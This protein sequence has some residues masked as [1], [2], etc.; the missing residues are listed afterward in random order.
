MDV[1]TPVQDKMLIL[2]RKPMNFADKNAVAVFKEN[3]IVG[4]VP[5]N[6]APSLSHFLKRDVNMVFGKVAGE[7]LTEKRGMDLEFREST[8]FMGQ[9]LTLAR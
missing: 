8:T 2:K 5:Y 7:K 6:V 4:L 3:K 1:W 9:K